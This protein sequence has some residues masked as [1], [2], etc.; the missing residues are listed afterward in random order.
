MLVLATAVAAGTSA[1]PDAPEQHK[2]GGHGGKDLYGIVNLEGG[3][4]G[5]IGDI[6]VRG[7]AAFEYFGIDG[8]L[9]VGFFDG[10]RVIDISPPSNVTALLGDLNDKG[11]VGFASSLAIQGSEGSAPFRPF[12]WSASR[13]LVPLPVLGE[14]PSFVSAIN[15]RSEI[16]G[17]SALSNENGAD[18]AVRWTAANRL[19]PLPAPAGIGQT[20][21]GDINDNN[22]SAGNGDTASGGGNVLVWDAYGRPTNLGA[23][24][25]SYAFASHINNR[26][27]I[28]GMIDVVTPNISAFL[29][30]PGKGV[31]RAGART[32]THGLNEIG[33][34][35]GRRVSG[36]SDPAPQAFVFS[37]ARGLVNLHLRGF[38]ASEANDVNDSSVVVGSGQ[39]TPG[40]YTAY[41][42]TRSGG[43]VDLNTRL[44]N[45]PSGLVVTAA[46]ALSNNGDILASANTGVVVLRANGGGTDAP[47]LGPIL[48]E[49]PRLNQPLALT[50]S[51]RDRNV[52]DTHTATID[53]G[54]GGGPQPVPLREYRGKG[55]VR[56][57][58]TYASEGDFNIVVRIRDSSGKS[59]QLF[60]RITIR[61]L[62]TPTASGQGLKQAQANALPARLRLGPMGLVR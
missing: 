53:W 9:H 8:L 36:N 54:D 44:L 23:F 6:N 5:F 49:P 58:H 27:D 10:T 45:P 37:R 16:V 1:T 18:R 40:D 62:G 48:H 19:T 15:N 57:S 11:E 55:E 46:L 7:Q 4:F 22:V 42:W 14:G 34:L 31:V 21:V 17:R 35:V 24:G 13:G 29:W 47:V 43:A 50:L 56:A 28:A 20:F 30:S 26:G 12:R 52:A 59:T 41:R 60:D 25:G 61:E 32:V 33:E 39:R 3:S 38:Y 2:A 51:F